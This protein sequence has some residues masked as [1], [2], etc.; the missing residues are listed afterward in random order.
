MNYLAHLYLS[1]Q[2]EELRL[3]NFLGDY[4]KGRNLSQFP[5]EVSRGINMHRQI[6]YFTDHHDVVKK[7]MSRLYKKYHKYAGVV[8]D[9]FYDYYLSL[10]W[11]T[12][13]NESLAHFIRAN[14]E[15]LIR[16]YEVLPRKA[17][18]QLPIIIGR[19]TLATYGQIKG[20]KETLKIVS[21]HT[22]LPK[23]TNFAIRVM[24]NNFEDFRNEFN[25]FFPDM[26]EY[27]SAVFGVEFDYQF[28]HNISA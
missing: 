15:I 21:R 27:V 11:K 3:G 2:S 17:Q 8:V 20:I 6:D 24:K 5:P 7:S 1:G 19:N 25:D 23:E 28:E 12:Y 14:Y 13:S 4:I 26:I 9:I 18:W 22:T 10:E 16:N